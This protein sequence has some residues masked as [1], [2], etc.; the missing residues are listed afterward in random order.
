MDMLADKLPVIISAL[1]KA[2]EGIPPGFKEKAE[3]MKIMFEA[4]GPMMNALAKV[5]E[6][7]EAS[8]EG[9]NGPAIDELFGG[10]AGALGAISTVMPGVIASLSTLPAA[11]DIQSQIDQLD[12]L[13]TACESLA[14]VLGKFS[15]LAAGQSPTMGER[16]GAFM[17][18]L[19]GMGDDETPAAKVIKAMVTDMN[20]I[21]EAMSNLPEVNISA[22]LK[23]IAEAFGVTESIAVENKPVNITINLNVTMDANKVGAVLVDKAVMTTPLATAGGAA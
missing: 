9:I 10:M 4:L 18:G 2:G 16:A 1:V 15:E 21:N 23:Q 8:L 22:N 6:I 17:K 14:N 11:A 12:L 20:N 3:S 5:Q 7:M 19:V 13:F